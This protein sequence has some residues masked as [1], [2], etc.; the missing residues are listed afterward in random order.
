MMTSV[1]EIEDKEDR[2]VVG[3]GCN[4]KEGGLGRHHPR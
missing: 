3:R 4:F 1:K 2:E